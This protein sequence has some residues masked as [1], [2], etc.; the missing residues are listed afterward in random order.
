MRIPLDHPAAGLRDQLN[1]PTQRNRRQAL[2]AV[3][4][5]RVRDADPYV[6]PPEK[7]VTPSG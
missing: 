7:N 6:K 1:S 2:T 4:S 5:F 3:G